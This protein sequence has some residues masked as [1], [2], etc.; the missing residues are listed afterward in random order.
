VVLAKARR[1][2]IAFQ[3]FARYTAFVLCKKYPVSFP[4]R[5]EPI[6]QCHLEQCMDS[7][8]RGNDSVAVRPGRTL[9]IVGSLS[10]HKQLVVSR[11]QCLVHG[12]ALH[13]RPERFQPKKLLTAIE[14]RLSLTHGFFAIKQIE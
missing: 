9:E 3:L 10:R 13:I 12:A 14:Q 1:V 6:T 8:L 2:N 11:Q 5:R 7:R 4:R